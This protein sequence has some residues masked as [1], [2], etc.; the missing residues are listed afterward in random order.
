MIES[1]AGIDRMKLA[2]L[3]WADRVVLA[4]LVRRFPPPAA[5]STSASPLRLG[6]QVTAAGA[7][8]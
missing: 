1:Y 3:D 7:D 4:A 2:R 8:F 5:G 6:A